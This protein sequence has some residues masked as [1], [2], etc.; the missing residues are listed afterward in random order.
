M[1][2]INLFSGQKDRHT[3]NKFVDTMGEGEGK[4]NWESSIEP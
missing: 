2:L 4:L 1:A 3:E